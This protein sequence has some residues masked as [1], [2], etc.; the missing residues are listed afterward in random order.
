MMNG[1]RGGFFQQAV[2]GLTNL[3]NDWYNGNAYQVYAFEYTPGADGDIV[4]FVGDEK[5]WKLDG[6]ALGPNGNV[7]QRTIPEE[8][9]SIILNFG[10]SQGFAPLNL[11]GLAPLLPATM[12]FDYVRIYQDPNNEMV[13]CDPPGYESTGYIAEHMDVYQNPNKTLWYVILCCTFSTPMLT[14]N[15]EQTPYS[16]PKNDFMQGC[17]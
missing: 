17:S 15:R 4:W 12:R 5:T 16:W 1:Y 7:G 10:M 9:M 8:P 6:R 14:S 11:T 2:S 3:N 13:S